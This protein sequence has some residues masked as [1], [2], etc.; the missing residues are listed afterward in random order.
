MTARLHTLN[1]A[2]DHVRYRSC[3]ETL[4]PGDVL[5][6]M[7]SGVLALAADPSFGSHREDV[8]VYVISGDVAACPQ[9]PVADSGVEVI[10]HSGFLELVRRIGSPLAW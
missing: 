7:E 1:K 3:L 8:Q 4:A 6:L 9:L 10:D 5:V 2:P